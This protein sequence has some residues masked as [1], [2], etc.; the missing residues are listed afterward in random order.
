MSAATP[1]TAAI[2]VTIKADLKTHVPWA[3]IVE[4]HSPW[5]VQ[6]RLHD[7]TPDGRH[8]KGDI[9]TLFWAEV[10]GAWCWALHEVQMPPPAG[11]CGPVTS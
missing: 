11:Y 7:G 6:A 4:M 10:M 9:V 1:T 3:T 5:H 8:G 2:G